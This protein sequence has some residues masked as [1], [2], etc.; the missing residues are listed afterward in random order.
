MVSTT[1]LE[2]FGAG[3]LVQ[4]GVWTV[5]GGEVTAYQ[6]DTLYPGNPTSPPQAGNQYVSVN[7]LLTNTSDEVQDIPVT[8]RC[9][10]LLDGDGHVYIGGFINTMH[11][12]PLEYFN[13]LPGETASRLLYYE[14]PAPA[15][16]WQYRSE[17]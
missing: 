10:E 3:E 15:A 14:T 7:W 13:A 5:V 12:H 6:S 1:T 8:P 11:T 9:F 16:G 17:C 2:A 4:R